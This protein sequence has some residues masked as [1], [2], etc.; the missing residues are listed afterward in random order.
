MYNKCNKITMI[1]RKLLQPCSSVS[2]VNY[3]SDAAIS[4]TRCCMTSIQKPV[5][6][7]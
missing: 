5:R 3:F 6:W 7:E 1:H 4:K 2:Y